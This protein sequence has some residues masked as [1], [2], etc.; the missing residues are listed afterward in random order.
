MSN[1]LRARGSHSYRWITI[2]RQKM[3]YA[4]IILFWTSSHLQQT[5]SLHYCNQWLPVILIRD[6]S[7]MFQGEYKHINAPSATVEVIQSP[8]PQMHVIY[9][10]M[11]T[12]FTNGSSYQLSRTVRIQP[13]THFQHQYSPMCWHASVHSGVVHH[14]LT[15]C[16][17]V[18]VSLP[19]ILSNNLD[20]I[21]LDSIDLL[22]FFSIHV[23]MVHSV[24]APISTFA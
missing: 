10:S 21:W 4:A 9:Y 12:H 11:L 6:S 1:V 13:S 18:Y 17:A 3:T 5:C 14:M 24:S 19:Q 22:I 2:I 23:I 20:W 15:E 16:N 8:H 7:T